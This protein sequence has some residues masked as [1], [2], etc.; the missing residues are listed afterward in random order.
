MG[1][2]GVSADTITLAWPADGR[3]TLAKIIHVEHGRTVGKEPS[4][5]V[6]TFEYLE[7]PVHDLRSLYLAVKRAAAQGAIAV[8]ARPKGPIG[9][10]R[11]HETEGIAPHLEVVP[12]RWVA[13]DWDGLPLELQP[14]P[15]SRWS[16][17]P[18]PLLEPW[19]GVR[20]ALRRL[21]PTFRE[22]A[23]FWQVTAGG[24]ID[25]GF[26]LRTWHWLDRPATGAELKVWLRPALERGLV[27]PSTLVECQPH[28]LGVQV[29]GDRDPCPRRFGFY[30]G[31]RHE[32]HVPDV[33]RIRRRQ[34]AL[35]LAKRPPPPPRSDPV[36]ANANGQRR[37][38]RCIDAVRNAPFGRRHPTYVAQSARA[39][40]LCELYC[41]DWPATEE[42]LRTAYRATLAPVEI[43]QRERS[44]TRGVLAWLDRRA[45]S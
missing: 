41:L 4:P 21:P 29:R 12:R 38:D 1:A 43:P 9:N 42:R 32:V 45:A 3:T 6:S 35:E 28:Y 26:R 31:D 15:N 34:R 20:I 24:G 2:L 40:K 33:E 10:R 30:G 22:I 44:S 7:A 27:D 18:D 5:N 16:W 25:D 11:I 8:R 19:V 39:Q 17:E 36:A 13:S 14:C 23:C 37:V